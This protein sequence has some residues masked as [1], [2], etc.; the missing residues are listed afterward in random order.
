MTSPADPMTLLGEAAAGMHEL[1]VS[2]RKA[3]FS[4]EESMELVR[5]VMRNSMPKAVPQVCPHCGKQS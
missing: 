2:F 3:G 1:H 5:E 4:R